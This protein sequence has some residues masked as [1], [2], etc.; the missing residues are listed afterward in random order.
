MFYSGQ[1]KNELQEKTKNNPNFTMLVKEEDWDGH[2][3]V[4]LS[5][6]TITTFSVL[7]D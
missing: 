2:N 6:P 1:A 3:S 7:T 5:Y 4:W